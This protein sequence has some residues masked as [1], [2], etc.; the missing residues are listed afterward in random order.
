M[1]GGSR[2][3]ASCV[4]VCVFFSMNW[5]K[6]QHLGTGIIIATI[7]HGGSFDHELRLHPCLH[8][9]EHAR[10]QTALDVKQP[11]ECS[12]QDRFCTEVVIVFF[13]IHHHHCGGPE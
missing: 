4:C 10:L 5:R 12:G 2:V 3:R 8:L 11:R 6:A 13:V 7:V 1:L 9:G